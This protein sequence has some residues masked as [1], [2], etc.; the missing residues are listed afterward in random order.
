M[1]ANAYHL[2]N[3]AGEKE[4][5]HFGRSKHK[6]LQAKNNKTIGDILR[7]DSLAADCHPCGLLKKQGPASHTPKA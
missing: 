4:H 5:T 2:P 6:F 1:L 7:E 3:I